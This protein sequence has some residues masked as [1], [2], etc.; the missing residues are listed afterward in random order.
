MRVRVDGETIIDQWRPQPATTY[1]A[2]RKLSAGSHTVVVQ[3]YEAAG[4]AVAKVSW[5]KLSSPPPPGSTACTDGSDNDSDK[6]IDLGDPGCADV[7]DNDESNPAAPPI[8]AGVQAGFVAGNTSTNAA[9]NRQAFFNLSNTSRNV[10]LEPGQYYVDQA[11][12]KAFIEVH[13][14][15]GTFAMKEGAEIRFVDPAGGGIKWRGGTGAK[16]IN[17]ESFHGATVRD[18][19]DSAL[20]FERTSN[21]QVNSATVHG[22][23]GA[24]I[25]IWRNTNVSVID[26]HAENTKADGMHIV[27]T[28][29]HVENW[30][31]YRTSD[32]GLSFQTYT[33]QY[34]VASGTAD[35][36]TAIQADTRG[37]TVLGS[38]DVTISNFVVRNSYSSGIYIECTPVYNDCAT[39]PVRNVL[40]EHG[41]VFDDG[42]HPSGTGPNPDSITV[43]RSP[44][45]D[46][47]FSDI[48][49]HTPLRDCYR[50]FYGGSATLINVHG[51]GAGC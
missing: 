23:G 35:G 17:W 34:P 8:P 22:A 11:A 9:T 31:A 2:T 13:N 21:L 20:D 40:Y 45:D 44:N 39:K 14:Y 42:R 10:T 49:S 19:L 51:D 29:A 36:V 26:S 48:E 4:A 50:A 1:T 47:V 43:W 38:Q 37:I 15:S 24:G 32:D 6:K 25:L 7:S 18:P 46:I 5:Q 33:G 41:K 28:D 12:T 27:A 30:S 3:Y 16:F